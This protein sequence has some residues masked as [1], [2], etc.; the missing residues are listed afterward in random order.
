MLVEK[1]QNKMFYLALHTTQDTHASNDI[2]HDAF[3]KA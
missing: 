1:H 2:V 3:I